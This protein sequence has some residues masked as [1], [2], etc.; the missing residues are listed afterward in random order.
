MKTDLQ[1]AQEN[2]M[3]HIDVIARKAKIDSQYIEYYGNYKAKINLSIMDKIQGNEDAKLILVTAINPTKS[4][5]GK[6]TTTIGLVDGLHQMNKQVIGCLRE[7]SLG[8]VFG[9]KGGATGGGFAQ[10]VPMEDINLHFTG[11]MHAITSANNL[12]S[13]LLDN[14]IYQGNE[15]NIDPQK[16][17]WKRCMDMNDRTLRS[18]TIAQD[19]K[20]NGIERKDGFII[21][22]AT[23]IMAILCLS[24]DLN[25]FEEKVNKAIV[26]YS[27]DD[28]PIT[29]KDLQAGGALVVLMKEALKPN[30]VQTLEKSPVLIHGGPFANIAHGCNSIIATKM[31]CKLAD[32]VVTEAGFGA[33]LGAEKFMDIKCRIGKLKPNAVVIVATVRA[34]KLHGGVSLD[35]LEEENMPALL[36]GI[37]N[38]EK[39][40]DSI[41]KFKVPYVVAINKFSKDTLA[42]IQQIINWCKSNGHEVVLS[43]AWASGG[44]G[45]EDLARKVIDLCGKESEYEPLY[46]LDMS[47]QEKIEVITRKIY[48]G[49]NVVFSDYAQ[50]QLKE[51]T[52]RGWD[53]LPI[54]MAKTPVSLS[55]DSKLIGRPVDFDIH[56]SELKISQ[57]AGFI[58]VFTGNIMTM[59]GLPSKPAALDMGIDDKGDT[60]GLF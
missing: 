42:E 25:D 23:E 29:I 60:I 34:L 54:C 58:V 10:V 55:D 5:E 16:I 6:S 53:Q 39:H 30:L 48:G 33:D 49:Q 41:Q 11:D 36:K 21:T 46:N 18:I 20:S 2:E 47:I 37:K 35:H 7:P 43:E 4:G 52:K 57:G 31:A 17:V 9:L 3:I 38:L 8:P 19:K 40:I 32:Y 12:V 14:H 1:I 51:Y 22:V 28:K 27:Y 24:K 13:A 26:A 15:L 44:A 56:V 59:P 50:L 45:S